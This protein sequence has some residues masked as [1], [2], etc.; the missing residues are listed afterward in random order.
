MSLGSRRACTCSEAG[1]SSQ[2]GDRASGVWY[3]WATFWCAFLWAKW[4]NAKKIHK[5]TFSVYCGKCLSCKEVRNCVEKSGKRFV[6]EKEVETEVRKWLR[7]QWKGFHA[8]GVEALV[9]RWDKCVNVGGEEVDKW[10]FGKVGISRFT[11]YIHL[12]LAYWLSL[13]IMAL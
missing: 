2:N 13:V 9:K 12:W 11:F 6:D 3:R 8:A 5:E 4:F 7:Q 1:F 10:Y